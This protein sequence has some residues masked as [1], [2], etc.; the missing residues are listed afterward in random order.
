M[1]QEFSKGDFEH[2][3]QPL[4][5]GVR[6]PIVLT[7]AGFDPSC[8]AGITADLK[9][10][11][12]HGTYGM[13]AITGL[14]VQ[15]TQGVRSIQPVDPDLLRQTLT[16]LLEDVAFDGIKIGMLASLQNL[17][18]IAE[19]LK[20]ANSGQVVLDPILR[21]TS[22]E[23]LSGQESLS[24]LREL[25]L[26]E[27]DWVTPNLAELEALTGEKVTDRGD[28]PS[29]ASLLQKKVKGERLN[30]LVTG[31]HLHVPEDYILTA[32]GESYWITGER[33]ETTSTHGTGCTFSSALL[34]ELIRGRSPRTAA[35]AAKGYVLEAL[36]QA[37]PVGKGHGPLNHLYRLDQSS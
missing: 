34:C 13:A 36:R 14:T 29:A 10:F 33:I 37:Y 30:V 5:T 9:V 6:R 32:E 3:F 18:I 7:I 35:E 15:S 23:L 20:S 4:G 12:A 16:C 11:A 1:N 31:G 21:S 27:V 26:P 22:G 8:G 17:K 25:L 24:E 28:I 19:F 2:L